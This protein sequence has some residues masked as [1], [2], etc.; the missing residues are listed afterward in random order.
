MSKQA[1]QEPKG[2]RPPT[3]PCFSIHKDRLSGYMDAQ[4]KDDTVKRPSYL[5]NGDSYSIGMAYKHIKA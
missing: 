2:L 4:Y 1:S 3:K 5:C